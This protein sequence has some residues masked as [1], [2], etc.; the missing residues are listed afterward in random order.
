M[1]L[2]SPAKVNLLL[3][4][5]GKRDDG[6]HNLV[7]LVAPLDF[8]DYLDVSMGDS[9]GPIRFTCS[10]STVPL[11]ADNLV[12]KAAEA[13][14]AA[15]GTELSLTIHLEKHIPMEAGLGG[16]SSNAA[17][18]LLALN[19]LFDDPL[20]IDRLSGLAADLG[21][22]CPLFLHQA[23]LIMRGRGEQIELLS[24]EASQRLRGQAL[25][26]FKPSI[27]ISTAWAYGALANSGDY[28]ANAE[29]V[30]S[31]LG[32]WKAGDLPLA[33]LLYNSFEAPVFEKFVAFPAL[34]E[35]IR[36]ELGLQPLMSGSGS[37]CLVVLPDLEMQEPLEALV[38][39]AFSE[40]AF[41]KVCRV[42]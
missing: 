1:R 13:F 33:A 11:G 8:G 21:S 40:S 23:P 17:T 29:D 37:S 30:E 20:D 28:Y 4:V 2:F 25:A 5:T 27:G 42:G 6:F 38:K 9:A 18:T 24:D 19:E 32:D 3:A 26:I 7:S 15:A 22:D 41:F 10:D 14:R 34:F 39:D 31:R 12:V 35:R 16:G 36:S